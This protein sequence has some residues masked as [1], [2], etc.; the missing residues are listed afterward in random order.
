M[1]FVKKNNQ[2]GVNTECLFDG[3]TNTRDGRHRRRFEFAKDGKLMP[4]HRK[5]S[6]LLI[7]FLTDIGKT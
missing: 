1:V 3:C 2:G 7:R 6:R 4:V 5:A